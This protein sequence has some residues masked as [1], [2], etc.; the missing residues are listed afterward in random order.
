M[1]R[2]KATIASP[3][4]VRSARRVVKDT[5]KIRDNKATAAAAAAATQGKRKAANATEAGP[6]SKKTRQGKNQAPKEKTPELVN[7]EEGSGDEDVDEQL[8][9]ESMGNQPDEEQGNEGD[10]EEDNG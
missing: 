6:S 3:R 10:E 2:S 8:L 1:P 7:A 5:E 9:R 4:P